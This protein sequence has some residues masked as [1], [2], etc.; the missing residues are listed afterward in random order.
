MSELVFVGMVDDVQDVHEMRITRDAIQ[1]ATDRGW[2]A[3]DEAHHGLAVPVRTRPDATGYSS[4][5]DEDD[6][7]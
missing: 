1:A 4:P 5:E 7:A 3:L 2:L 6:G